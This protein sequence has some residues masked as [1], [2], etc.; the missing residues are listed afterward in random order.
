MHRPGAGIWRLQTEDSVEVDVE[1]SSYLGDKGYVERCRQIVL[2]G[3][4]GD[5]DRTSVRWAIKRMG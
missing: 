2:T 1:D 5:T 4:L 3:H